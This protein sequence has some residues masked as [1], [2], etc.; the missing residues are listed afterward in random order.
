MKTIEE[1]AREFVKRVAAGQDVPDYINELLVECYCSA[2]MEERKLL[3]EWHDAKEE[4]PKSGLTV[5]IKCV[6]IRFPNQSFFTTGV[7][8]ASTRQWCASRYGKHIEIVGWRDI[9]E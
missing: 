7:Y 5:L 8:Y 3:T 1:R 2:A 6:D 9:H 4:H